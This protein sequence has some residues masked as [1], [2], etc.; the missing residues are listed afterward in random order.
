MYTKQTNDLNRRF[1]HQFLNE[2]LRFPLRKTEGH[3][4]VGSFSPVAHLTF[5]LNLLRFNNCLGHIK[6]IILYKGNK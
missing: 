5:A 6:R 3:R 2:S 1:C 4:D